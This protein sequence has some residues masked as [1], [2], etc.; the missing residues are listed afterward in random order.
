M[1]NLDLATL[2]VK[3]QVE[4]GEAKQKIEETGRAAEEQKKKV[5]NSWK[6]AGKTMSD[7]GGK[8]TKAITVPLTA[9]GTACVKLASDLTET[10][11]KTEV[12]FGGMSDAVIKWSETAVENM[13][14]AQETALNMASTYGDLGTSMGLTTAQASEM[15]MSL[16]Q[17]G[18]D[19]ASFK[20]I[21]IERANVALQAIYTGETESLKAMGIVMTEAN[22]EA[23]AMNQ[24]LSTTYKN[25]TQAEKVMLR[26]QYV[27]SMTANAQGDFVRT[28]DS[29]ANQTR[30]LGQNIKELGASFGKL[31]EPAITSIVSSLNNVVSWFRSLSDTA[32]R[33]IITVGEIIA[34]VPALI[35]GIGGIISIIGK[36]QGAMTLLFANP[37]VATITI[38]I[39]A[40]TALGVAIANFAGQADDAI[41]EADKLNESLTALEAYNDKVIQPRA[42][43]ETGDAQTQ[44][45]TLYE[46]CAEIAGI[47]TNIEYAFSVSNLDGEGGVLTTLGTAIGQTQ[48]W[49]GEMEE[50]GKA[51]DAMLEKEKNYIITLSASQAIS[52]LQAY[53]AGLISIE[54][55]DAGL[56]AVNSQCQAL[57]TNLDAN[58]EAYTKLTQ[59]L[60]DGDPSNDTQAWQDFYD[61]MAQINP[62]ITETATG[63]EAVAQASGRIQ[64]AM[65]TSA[66]STEAMTGDTALLNQGLTQ[67]GDDMENKVVGAYDTYNSAIEDANAKEAEGRQSVDENIVKIGEQ[68]LALSQFTVFLNENGQNVGLAM[69]QMGQFSAQGLQTV[70]DFYGGTEQ[71]L[72]TYSSQIHDDAYQLGF[73]LAEMMRTQEADKQAITDETNQVRKD[74]ETQ[75]FT[76]LSSITSGYNTQELL[77]MKAQQQ[78]IGNTEGEAQV[79]RVLGL[80]GYCE[81][82]EAMVEQNCTNVVELNRVCM[83]DV[84]G[85]APTANDAGNSVGSNMGEGIYNGLDGWLDRI[86]EK[87]RQAIRQAVNEAQKE[88]DI[89]SPSRKTR[90]LIG[91]PFMEGIEVGMDDYMPSLLKSTKKNMSSIISAGTGVINAD[92]KVSPA[93]T[94]NIA[95][96]GN[97]TINQTNNFTSR[98]LSP[99]EQQQQIR[100]MNK[101]LAEVFA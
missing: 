87:A 86:A 2:K 91:E 54:E 22:L 52:I 13:G 15:S 16:V 85:L 38:V 59:V 77:A 64:E 73:Q 97:T 55:R 25:M 96:Q 49:A 24:G 35:G 70:V 60:N 41:E 99:Y 76:D 48:N 10:L 92:Y 98:T 69:E 78:E 1:A 101:Q 53:N 12:V 74:A 4:N 27:M 72:A 5:E 93:N 20:N 89:H 47:D 31:L 45:E 8:L 30:K 46:K 62:V 50:L 11:G 9:I 39:G 6:E 84:V 66:D 94:T 63:A 37:V 82:A 14:L 19:M 71:L 56:R 90:K 17:L 34:I 100:K 61:A 32:K 79:D 29:L 95:R 68:Q 23:F 18:A 88:A 33:V 36:L 7:V 21:S 51:F 65:D 26:Y 81:T 44:A 43:F 83:N 57:T 42:E 75:L 58:S 80:Q 28:G 40:L 67:I 3:V